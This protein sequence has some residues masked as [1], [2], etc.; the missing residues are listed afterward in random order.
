MSTVEK[1][2]TIVGI[3]GVITTLTLPAHHSA[4]LISAIG[5]FIKNA[6]YTSI[7]GKLPPAGK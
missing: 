6:E 2:I 3:I 5:S 4:T 7:S 1:F